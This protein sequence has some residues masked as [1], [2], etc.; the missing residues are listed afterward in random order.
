M[1]GPGTSE[2]DVGL[3]KE[4]A[5]ARDTWAGLSGAG[6]GVWPTPIFDPPPWLGGVS[7]TDMTFDAVGA[8]QCLL[9]AASSNATPQCFRVRGE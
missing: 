4:G 3:P 5:W 7:G 9:P 2:S 1:W 6:P 8:L